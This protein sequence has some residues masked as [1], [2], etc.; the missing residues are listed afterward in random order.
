MIIMTET[1]LFDVEDGV[2]FRILSQLTKKLNDL[3]GFCMLDHLKLQM[4]AFFCLVFILHHNEVVG[5]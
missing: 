3:P 4:M 2:F 1:L 5:D